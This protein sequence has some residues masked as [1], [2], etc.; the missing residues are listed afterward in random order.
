MSMVES[1]DEKSKRIMAS[2]VA[3]LS[4]PGM[5]KHQE[6]KLRQNFEGLMDAVDFFGLMRGEKLGP[7]PTLPSPE[8]PNKSILDFQK[9]VADELLAKGLIDSAY[10]YALKQLDFWPRSVTL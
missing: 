9:K 10:A 3:P 7:I 5:Q 6:D 4:L 1:W 2:S 8:T